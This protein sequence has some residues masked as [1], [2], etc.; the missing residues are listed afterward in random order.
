MKAERHYGEQKYPKFSNSSLAMTGDRDLL[1]IYIPTLRARELYWHCCLCSPVGGHGALVLAMLSIRTRGIH[2]VGL[3]AK[4]QGTLLLAG[5]WV[6]RTRGKQYRLWAEVFLQ[7][8][9][10]YM[11]RCGA[12][13][14]STFY[15]YCLLIYRI[16]YYVLYIS[17][18][19]WCRFLGSLHHG[20]C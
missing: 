5:R 18:R 1:W 8:Y 19:G 14:W 2:S 20:F 13:V 9:H 12:T 15:E 17:F 10:L 3:S 11:I 7:W 4:S 16:S 6:H